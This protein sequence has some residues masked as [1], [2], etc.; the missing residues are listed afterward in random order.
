[1]TKLALTPAAT[2]GDIVDLERYP[3]TDRTNPAYQ[4]LVTRS[5]SLL[6]EERQNA[7]GMSLGLGATGIGLTTQFYGSRQAG[8]RNLRIREQARQ[9]QPRQR[10]GLVKGTAAGIF[11][12]QTDFHIQVRGQ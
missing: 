5:Q 11:R 4:A 2:L 7:F 12:Q 9:A 8:Q 6:G 1:M 3:I 10:T